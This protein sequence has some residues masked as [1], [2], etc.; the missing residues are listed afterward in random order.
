MDLLCFDAPP[1]PAPP[2][3]VKQPPS[4]PPTAPAPAAPTAADTNTAACYEWTGQAGFSGKPPRACDAFTGAAAAT[5]GSGDRAQLRYPLEWLRLHV[6][7]LAKELATLQ[8]A[9]RLWEQAAADGRGFRSSEHKVAPELQGVA[10]N[11][12]S[13]TFVLADL[14][15]LLAAGAPP[16]ALVD[17]GSSSSST[18]GAPLPPASP[19]GTAAPTMPQDLLSGLPSQP[20]VPPPASPSSA[21]T[22]P[23]AAASSAWKN[24]L[25]YYDLVSAGAPTAHALGF[26]SG[27]LLSHHAQMV[28]LQREMLALDAQVQALA[29]EEGV[30]YCICLCVLCGLVV[31]CFGH[32][33]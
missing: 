19:A 11:V 33:V 20:P 5:T 10:T 29:G 13:Q 23:I 24:R 25:H 26:R 31:G 8:S 1:L 4:L 18:T 32:W 22:T 12:H 21:T 6:D 16:G 28:A 17:S 2:V 14:G 27:G 7:S 15:G 30:F 3:T 9:L